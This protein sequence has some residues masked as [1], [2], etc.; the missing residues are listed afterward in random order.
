MAIQLINTV[1]TSYKVYV[2]AVKLC[3]HYGD[4]ALLLV[5]V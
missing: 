1:T 3:D 4:D 5:T 2:I